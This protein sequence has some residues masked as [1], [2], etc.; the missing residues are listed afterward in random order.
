MEMVARL[1]WS[2][3]AKRERTEGA[4]AWSQRVTHGGL[5]Q[6]S[7]VKT[8]LAASSAAA[9]AAADLGITPRSRAAL[10]EQLPAEFAPEDPFAQHLPDAARRRT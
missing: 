2:R 3:I 4:E 10:R 1:A 7:D 5:G 9:A 8:A 6:H